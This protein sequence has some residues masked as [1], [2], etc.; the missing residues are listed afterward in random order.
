VFDPKN[1]FKEG[2]D[3]DTIPLKTKEEA[4]RGFETMSLEDRLEVIRN[5]RN[6][7][8]DT[9]VANAMAGTDFF[10]DDNDE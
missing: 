1:I 7:T 8:K 4:L 3:L 10:D 6:K 9:R 5:H 2:H